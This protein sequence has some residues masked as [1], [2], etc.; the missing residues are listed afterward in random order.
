[1]IAGW[2]SSSIGRAGVS[3]TPGCGSIPSGPPT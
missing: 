1:M 2:A 3:K